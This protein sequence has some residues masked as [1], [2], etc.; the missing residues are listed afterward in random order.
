MDDKNIMGSG[1]SFIDSILDFF[2]PAF[3][4][5]IT[6]YEFI[7]LYPKLAEPQESVSKDVLIDDGKSLSSISSFLSQRYNVFLSQFAELQFYRFR[8]TQGRIAKR[9]PYLL[10]PNPK[11][12]AHMNKTNIVVAIFTAFI[13]GFCLILSC[14]IFRLVGSINS[15]DRTVAKILGFIVLAFAGML[16]AVVW[17]TIRHMKKERQRSTD[18]DIFIYFNRP[19]S[20]KWKV[21]S[22][23]NLFDNATRKS[24][25]VTRFA[26]QFVVLLVVGALLGFDGFLFAAEFYYSLVSVRP[27]SSS[28]WDN[29]W[30]VTSNFSRGIFYTVCAV[31]LLRKAL[32]VRRTRSNPKSVEIE[33]ANNFPGEKENIEF[34]KDVD[35]KQIKTNE[36]FILKLFVENF[37]SLGPAVG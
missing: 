24:F 28:G 23:I 11:A 4:I 37:L 6:V 15:P 9:N 17:S 7:V 21:E 13:G 36:E 34:L 27:Q 30:K 18:L 25:P 22:E 14:K 12:V 16:F 2:V 1:I 10:D 29:F 26:R 33:I 8:P 32:Q 20:T 35:G 31:L 19:Q 5:G 3:F